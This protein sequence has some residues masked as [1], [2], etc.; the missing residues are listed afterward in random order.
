MMIDPTLQVFP[1]GTLLR[2]LY[3]LQRAPSAMLH[4]RVCALCKDIVML[5]NHG[6]AHEC[7]TREVVSL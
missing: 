5:V 6:H 7:G 4:A 1:E 3:N 2:T